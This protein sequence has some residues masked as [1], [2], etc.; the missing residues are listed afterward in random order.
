M[1]R[2][3]VGGTKIETAA[4]LLRHGLEDLPFVLIRVRVPHASSLE[5]EKMN[6]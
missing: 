3:V 2:L 1:K 6:F 5:N 4:V